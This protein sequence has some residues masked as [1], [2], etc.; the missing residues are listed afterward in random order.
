MTATPDTPAAEPLVAPTVRWRFQR[1]D[2]GYCL[3]I[4]TSPDPEDD[5]LSL[6]MRE[7]EGL[8]FSGDC[9]RVTGHQV[10]AASGTFTPVPSPSQVAG[11]INAAR[12][13]VI[14]ANVEVY[15]AFVQATPWA[16]WAEQSIE[17]NEIAAR[18][19]VFDVDVGNFVQLAETYGVIVERIG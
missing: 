7:D 1:T 15:V 19:V 5:P 8:A 10:A 13:L 14:A 11:S 18:V 4:W 6:R 9:D 17:E 12:F 2:T 16:N 3:I